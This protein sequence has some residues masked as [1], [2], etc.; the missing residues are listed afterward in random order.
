MRNRWLFRVPF[1]S[2]TALAIIT[3]CWFAWDGDP[4]TEPWTDL[5]TAYVPAEVTFAAI[6]ALALWVPIHFG[7]RYW[8]KAQNRRTDVRE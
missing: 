4:Q 7:I 6:G 5:L 1:L 2:F 3:E 8:R